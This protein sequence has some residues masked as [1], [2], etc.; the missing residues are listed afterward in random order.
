[1]GAER[2]KA[3]CASSGRTGAVNEQNT[4]RFQYSTDEEKRGPLNDKTKTL[5]RG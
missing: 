2:E 4:L 1:M 3:R 5:G